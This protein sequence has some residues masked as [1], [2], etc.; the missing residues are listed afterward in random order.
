MFN[1]FE[2][3]P[4]T[5]YVTEMQKPHVLHNTNVLFLEWLRGQKKSPHDIRLCSVH[6]TQHD[7]LKGQVALCKL[8]LVCSGAA[9]RIVWAPNSVNS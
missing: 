1:T 4:L 9:V 7:A 8:T 6:R 2:A 5:S 3:T